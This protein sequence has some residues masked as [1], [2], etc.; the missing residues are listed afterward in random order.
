M[1]CLPQNR[2]QVATYYAGLAPPAQPS[3]SPDA[4]SIE[5]GRTLAEQGDANAKVPA[6]AGCHSDT[7]LKTYPEAR[8]TER[9]LY[10]QPVAALEERPHSR[11]RYR[12]DHGAD[13]QGTDRW[14]DR[15]CIGLLLVPPGKVVPMK[16]WPTLVG[17]LAA[18]SLLGGCGAD[19]QSA[20][21][22]RGVQAGQI[23][24]LSWI[25]FGFAAVVLGIVMA[26][27]WLAIRGSPRTRTLLSRENAVLGLGIVFPAVTLTVLLGY[28]VWLM[29][30]QSGIGDNRNAVGIEVT[31]EQW[32]WRVRLWSAPA[33]PKSPAPMKFVFLWGNQ[34]NSCSNPPT[35]SIASGCQ[36]W[37]ARWI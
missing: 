33:E 18:A 28:G 2:K 21:S 5:R 12:H 3:R 11:F 6:C 16:R 8:R 19:V 26:A 29:R 25:L 14:A 23:A 27:L 37:A 22:P 36:V 15:R 9:R 32:W 30:A 24:L 10:R 20:L 4:A 1:I 34:S 31:G 17:V 7:S 13:R 35:S